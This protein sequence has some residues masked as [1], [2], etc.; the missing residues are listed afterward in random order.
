MFFLTLNTCGKTRHM[1]HTRHTLAGV[2]LKA[3]RR[4]AAA[5]NAEGADG[6]SNANTVETP[7]HVNTAEVR[8]SAARTH[9][10]RCQHSYS[11]LSVAH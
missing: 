7:M 11:T 8:S 6:L 9:T 10:Q 5:L 1:R 3:R 4:L 2:Q